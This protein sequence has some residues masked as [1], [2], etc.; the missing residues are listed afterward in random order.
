[1]TCD[2][3]WQVFN[4]AKAFDRTDSFS[5][6]EAD[7]NDA[8]GSRPAGFRFG[9]PRQNDLEFF[10]DRESPAL[11][12]HAISNLE[13]SKGQCV[14][15]DFT[16][17]RE[18]A[19]LL[20]EGPWVAERLAALKLFYA[21]HADAFLPVIRKIIGRASRFS[22]VDAFDAVYRLQELKRQAEV[23]WERIDALLVPTA[24]TI[25]TLKQ[26]ESD[27]IA[28]NNNLGYYTNF[29]NLMDLC[30]L[31][32][33]CTFRRTGLPFGVTVIAP[34]FSDRMLCAVGAD[35][36]ARLGLR[37]GATKNQLR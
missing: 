26:V 27:P 33:P 2:D 8:T 13:R 14:E 12:A 32:V 29:V 9:V 1:L 37:L 30:A 5:R 11:F 23:E 22:A 36:Q 10:G 15:I 3:A 25:Y 34:A 35:Y 31:A 24:G 16:R 19:K 6:A 28:L 17:F 20:Y 18:A 21:A 4:V 7:R